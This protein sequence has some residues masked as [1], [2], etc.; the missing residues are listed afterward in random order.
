M[1]SNVLTWSARLVLILVMILAVLAFVKPQPAYAANDRYWINGTGNWNDT[2]HWSASDGGGGG[3]SVPG[4]TNDVHF[5][6]A[7]ASGTFTVTLN[8]SGSCG[9]M[10]WSTIDD[11][12]TFTGTGS[13]TLAIYGY[14]TKSASMTWNIQGAVTFAATSGP[15]TITNAGKNYIANVAFNGAGGSWQ[16]VDT[17]STGGNITL[18]N[19]TVDTNGQTVTCFSLANTTGTSTLTL[20]A[21]TF[22]C[23]SW[24]LSVGTTTLNAGTST[25]N[26]IQS[27]TIVP[28]FKG[29]SKTYYNVSITTGAYPYQYCLLTGANTFNDLSLYQ[30]D[31]GAYV[32]FDG[33]NTVSGTFTANG[34]SH[35][36]RLFVA[37][38]NTTNQRTITAAVVSSQYCDYQYISGAGAASPWSLAAG[39]TIEYPGCSTITA[40]FPYDANEDLYWTGLYNAGVGG[41]GRWYNLTGAGVYLYYDYNWSTTSGG[42]GG[43]ARHG[44]PTSTN[45]VYFDAGSNFTVGNNSVDLTWLSSAPI[46]CKDID[47]T[48]SF[49]TAYPNLKYGTAFIYPWNIYGSITLIAGMTTDAGGADDQYIQ[50][51]GSG[52]ITSAGVIWQDPDFRLNTAGTYTLQDDLV[53]NVAA[54]NQVGYT[55]TA[56]TLNTNSKTIKF[57][58][59]AGVTFNGGGQ[60]YY[61]VEAYHK[62]IFTVNGANNFTN[63]KRICSYTNYDGMKFGA[64]QTVVN[65]TLT[66]Y[67]QVYR[68]YL[69]STVAGTQRQIS[70]SGSVNV[71]LFDISD[72]AK[73]GAASPDISAGLNSDL[74][75]NLGWI[76]TPG[77]NVYWVGDSGNW[78]DY[79]NHWANSTGGT[80]GTGH[81][82]LIQDTAVINGSSM[83]IAGRVI[84]ID[85]TTLSGINA[86]NATLTP[87]IT[88][89][90]TIDVY[91]DLKLGNVTYTVTTTNLKGGDTSLQSVVTMTTNLHIL[92][93]ANFMSTARLTGNVTIAGTVYVDSGTF[94]HDGWNLTAYFYD[95]STTTYNRS[96]IL[97]AGVTTLNGTTATTKWN[98]AAANLSFAAGESTIILTNSTANAQTFAGAGLTYNNV[99]IAGAGAYSTTISG[100]NTIGTFTI[101]RSQANKTLTGSVT[102][103]ISDASGLIVNPSSTRTITITNT[104]F[105]MASGIVL[106]DY[107]IISGSSAS[108]GASFF[109]SVAGHST[110]N[111]GNTGWIWI[112][113]TAPTIQTN[114]ASDVNYLGERLNG[115]LLTKGSYPSFKCYFEY[116]PTVA[117]GFDTE[118]SATTLTDVGTFNHY[119]SPYKVYHYRAVVEF[120]LNDHAYG[121]DKTV[122]LS[123]AVT[124]A[125]AAVSDP[126]E[127]AGTAL[128]TS[129]PS[130][131]GRMYT[132][133]VDPGILGLGPLISQAAAPSNTP[134]EAIWWPVSFVLALIAGFAAYGATRTLLIQ[135]LVSALVMAA[136]AGGGLLGDGILPYWPVLLF[137]IEAILI[138]LID[139][140]KQHA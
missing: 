21:S 8:V 134:L 120:G 2:A 136:F 50:L 123:G 5:T 126:G 9:F 107:L 12:A 71:S 108:G 33:N 84:T 32:T 138:W 105:S 53:I 135:A 4:S 38:N 60:T 117:Y 58:G 67:D 121:N 103:T 24:D 41:G 99:T 102:I 90:G 42:A 137:S 68:G 115:Q 85:T 18:Y 131:P 75:G 89:S 82:P 70:V 46:Q 57:Y 16:F 87:T 1:R 93:N 35:T 37:S 56:G 49:G 25:I 26:V 73:V 40:T 27:S 45:N 106:G 116:G 23:A 65:L 124:Q 7:S 54:S 119:L 55:W 63:L 66:G 29:A 34:T 76:F 74:G 61:A 100:T 6:A 95:S 98:M 118:S 28:N 81:I 111:G 36:N 130:A 31:R 17:F 129:V 91:G 122:S 69:A 62:Y 132:N 10:D 114:D 92:K 101:D 125:Q 47:F 48:G 44:M 77:S 20:G 133:D 39:D 64:D 86:L 19:G 97:S 14:L 80:P 127:G 13:Y 72:S 104:D 43:A 139:V 52:N 51:L 22:N 15:K 140:G 3:A 128:I 113:P 112:P 79:T 110:D 78:S 59:D 30:V 83:S 94:N 96:I 88:K 109:A 11:S